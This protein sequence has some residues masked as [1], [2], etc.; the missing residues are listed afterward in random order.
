MIIQN[1]VN[2]EFQLCP[3]GFVFENSSMSCICAGSFNGYVICNEKEYTATMSRSTWIGKI[4]ENSRDLVVGLCPY[5]AQYSNDSILLPTHITEV[6]NVVCDYTREG[7]LC[8]KC[9]EGYSASTNTNDR[10]CVKCNKD[11]VM[12]NWLFYV[13]AEIVPAT[14]FIII[15][16]I[17]SSVIAVGPLNSFIFFAQI[18]Y[19]V[20]KIGAEGMIPLKQNIPNFEISEIFLFAPYEFWNLHFAD[21]VLPPFCLGTNLKTLDIYALEYL[22]MT[23]PLLLLF[24]C[25][26]VLFF[27]NRGNRFFVFLFR[28]VHRVLARFRTFTGLRP[29][30]TGGIAVFILVSYTKCALTSFRFFAYIPLY[31]STGSKV[32]TVFYYD[33]SVRF[34]E[35]GLKYIIVAIFLLCTFVLIPPILLFYPTLVTLIGKLSRNYL[36]LG[37]FYP[38]IKLQAFFDEFHGCYK[39]GSGQGVDCRWFSS[40]YFFLR[41]ILFVIYTQTNYWHVQYVLMLLIF[42]TVALIFALVRPYKND[43]INNLDTAMFVNL[44]AITAISQFELQQTKQGLPFNRVSFAIQIILVIA[45]MLYLFGYISLKI[46]LNLCKKYKPDWNKSSQDHFL[47]GNDCCSELDEFQF[48]RELDNDSEQQPRHNYHAIDHD[49][50]RRSN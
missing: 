40:F 20:V 27:Y 11:D 49:G 46:I 22:T 10:S 38:G 7:V 14:I 1:D 39:D 33:G 32:E 30:V 34:P 19:S 50:N 31:N 13:L 41:I 24:G 4:K 2:I 29:S 28:P 35:E 9:K 21:F 47:P 15:I 23:I 18:I 45:P 43:W 36:T 16:F 42:L 37:R 8:G 48:I 26:V 5:T 6:N 25:M 17:F 3:P 12:L 44:A